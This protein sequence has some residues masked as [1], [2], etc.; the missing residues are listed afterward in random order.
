[1]NI[2]NQ[3]EYLKKWVP[4]LRPTRWFVI[5]ECLLLYSL[6]EIAVIVMTIKDLGARPY[7]EGNYII[8]SFL[9]T[10][11]WCFE[12]GLESWWSIHNILVHRRES[13]FSDAFVWMNVIESS[14]AIYFLFD[15]ATLLFE[16]KVKEQDIEASLFDVVLNS[17]FYLYATIRDFSR[18][19]KGSVMSQMSPTD[20]EG[21]AL[22]TE[23][24]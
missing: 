9:T 11:V 21:N 14:A 24:L 17:V 4:S 23:I 3:E 22:Y 16:W 18:I 8:W 6:I 15:T 12:S 5:N 20:D 13:F 7:V 1:M 19:M 10:V 2:R